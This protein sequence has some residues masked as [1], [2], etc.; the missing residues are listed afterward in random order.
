[1][2]GWNNLEMYIMTAIK[3]WINENFQQTMVYV[4]PWPSAWFVNDEDLK[5]SGPLLYHS[6]AFP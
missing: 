1:M 4:K 6:T 5:G 3:K 2:G